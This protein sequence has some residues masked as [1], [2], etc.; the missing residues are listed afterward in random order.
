MALYSLNLPVNLQQDAERCAQNQGVSLDEFILWAVAEKIGALSQSGDDAAFP[1]IRYRSGASG[2]L[3]P[4]LRGT[5]LRVQTV[6]IAATKWGLSPQ[7]VAVEYDLSENQ[8]NQ[9]LAFYEVHRQEI[10]GAIATEQT[11]EFT[12]V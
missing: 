9:A 12:H 11:I 8:V 6:V 5:N 2:Q 3:L 7:Q 1:E 10:D 4:V